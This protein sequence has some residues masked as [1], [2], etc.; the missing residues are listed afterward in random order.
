MKASLV[1]LLLAAAPALADNVLS[2]V[3]LVCGPL[4]TP[5][6]GP[7]DAY[8]ASTPV[9]I[10]SAS[11]AYRNCQVHVGLHTGGQCQQEFVLSLTY[12]NPD[13]STHVAGGLMYSD[14]VGTTCPSATPQNST[15]A[16]ALSTGKRSSGQVVQDSNSA[17]TC[18]QSAVGTTNAAGAYLYWGGSTCPYQG[19]F[20]TYQP[21][22]PNVI[23]AG[24]SNDSPAF[25]GTDTMAVDTGGD[26][27]FT[28]YWGD[29]SA[30]DF[31]LTLL[32]DQG[33]T[34]ATFQYQSG[35]APVGVASFGSWM[36]SQYSGPNVSGTVDC[37]QVRAGQPPVQ[38]NFL[39]NTDPA[40]PQVIP[41]YVQKAP[42]TGIPV[43][44]YAYQAYCR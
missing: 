16:E 14:P 9:P 39:I 30:H 18:T 12:E 40:N 23:L 31:T 10:V 24:V 7:P 6:D 25:D 22:A 20:V 36:A 32:T 8:L 5:Q 1:L 42:C 4:G 13:G 28:C 43:G 21:P 17:P 38:S 44:S 19:P 11:Y 2:G 29:Q 37:S 3:H 35:N 41:I 26:L 15:H 34:Y 27:V 33:S